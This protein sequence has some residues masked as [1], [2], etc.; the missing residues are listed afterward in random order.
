MN[1]P[2]WQ[3]RSA[4]FVVLLT[5]SGCVVSSARGALRRTTPL[6]DRCYDTQLR[7]TLTKEDQALRL[8]LTGSQTCNQ[9]EER[10]YQ[11]ERVSTPGLVLAVGAGIVAGAAVGIP[12][13]IGLAALLGN[14]ANNNAATG[15]A[16]AMLALIPAA[17]V[18]TAAAA[19]VGSFKSKLPDETE[20]VEHLA[21]TQLMGEHVPSGTLRAEDDVHAWK[22]E[23]GQVLLP[24]EDL[25]G[26]RL[27]RLLLNGQLVE[28]GG[29]SARRA[30]SLDACRRAVKGWTPAEACPEV[31]H[32]AEAAASCAEFWGSA[33]DLLVRVQA[34]APAGAAR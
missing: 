31:L 20:R 25:S 33:R 21:G 7:G 32:R 16:M 8:R 26:V 34:C 11:V 30:D 22:V 24:V 28:L 10:E 3:Q 13:V 1:Q 29:E 18:G 23:D 12:A 14:N 9:L 4:L 27:S 2:R 17:G 6:P 15:D 19:A 5:T